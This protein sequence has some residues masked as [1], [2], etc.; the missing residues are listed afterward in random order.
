MVLQKLSSS[1]CF[2]FP[3]RFWLILAFPACNLGAHLLCIYF[4][5]HLISYQRKGGYNPPP[6]ASG[7]LGLEATGVI[8]KVGPG[9]PPT[10]T[11]GQKV[12]A[13]LS[14]KLLLLLCLICHHLSQDPIFMHYQRK[15]DQNAF[16]FG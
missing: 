5:L 2:D 8:D 15:T 13:L 14:G 12:M 9:C 6:G 7:I 4:A 11:V 3:Y 10:V 1:L 16:V